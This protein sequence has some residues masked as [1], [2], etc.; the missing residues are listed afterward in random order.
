MAKSKSAT[1]KNKITL[2]PKETK[3]KTESKKPA[4]EKKDKAPAYTAKPRPYKAKPVKQA[5]GGSLYP[6]GLGEEIKPEPKPIE[7]PVPVPAA[8]PVPQ[9]P[10]V[11]RMVPPTPNRKRGPKDLDYMLG[12]KK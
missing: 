11:N 7:A 9:K 2:F 4:A 6:D 10:T 1:K 8:A 12:P 3:K 5:K